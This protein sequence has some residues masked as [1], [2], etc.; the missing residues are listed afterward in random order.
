MNSLER[1]MSSHCQHLCFS[2]AMQRAVYIINVC[3]QENPNSMIR[4]VGGMKVICVSLHGGNG[5]LFI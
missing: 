5:R 2:L 4:K 1:Q 3:E